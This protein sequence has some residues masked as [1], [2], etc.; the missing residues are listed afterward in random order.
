[1]YYYALFYGY[2]LAA[3]T[4]MLAETIVYLTYYKDIIFS[5]CMVAMFVGMMSSSYQILSFAVWRILSDPD[6]TIKDMK[7]LLE[8]IKNSDSTIGMSVDE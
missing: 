1:M 6:G 4:A 5:S 3:C 8:E 2:T 7:K